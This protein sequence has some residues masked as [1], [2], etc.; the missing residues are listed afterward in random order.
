MP[1]KYDDLFDRFHSIATTKSGTR[2]EILAA[3]VAKTLEESSA[4]IHDLRLLGDSDVKHQIDV[5]IEGSNGRRSLLIECKDYD[6]SEDKI[7]LGTVRDFW[8]VVDDTKPDEAWIMTCN[9]FTAGALKFARAKGI[10]PVIM[11]TFEPSDMRGRIQKIR[12]RIIA[13]MPVEPMAMLY[14]EDQDLELLNNALTSIGRDQGQ[15]IHIHDDAYF[16]HPTEGSR[17]L[18][19]VLSA[20]INKAMGDRTEGQSEAIIHPNGKRLFVGGVDV[21]YKGIIVKFKIASEISTTDIVSTKTAELILEGVGA[22]DM[23]IFDEQIQR[24]SIDPDTG[25]IV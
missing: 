18:N 6:L 25:E 5:T 7:G 14:V 15:P 12:L 9:G 21:P 4:V 11:R 13:R 20:D 24:R 23:I 1:S 3:M 17:R 16:D 10:K 8:A 19:D 22:A 2:Y